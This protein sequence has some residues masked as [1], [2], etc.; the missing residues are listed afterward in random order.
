[1][2]TKK[3]ADQ[4]ATDENSKASDPN[5]VGSQ[6]TQAVLDRRAGPMTPSCQYGDVYEV[7]AGSVSRKK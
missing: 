7:T 3:M 4:S 1:M 2:V 5:L 6:A